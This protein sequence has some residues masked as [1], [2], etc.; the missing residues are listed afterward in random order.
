[1]K[2]LLVNNNTVHM[3]AI[4]R[5]LKGHDIEIQ[6][7]QPGIKFHDEGKD[8][9]ILSGGGGEGLEITDKISQHKLWY[10][11]EM[12]F[13]RTTDKPLFGI[14][15]G[16]EVIVKA[17]GGK[18]HYRPKLTYGQMNSHTTAQGQELLGEKVINQVEAHYWYVPEVPEDQLEILARS[19]SGIEMIRH[20]QRQI[21]GS[22]FHPEEGGTLK[23]NNLLAQFI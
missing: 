9:I 11:D 13:V 2:I 16:F 15:M 14:C 12:E 18:V 4:S 5:Q 6:K 3:D 21:M 17:Y 19:D 8:L 23:L 22:Q 1:M 20:R 7:Y 10:E